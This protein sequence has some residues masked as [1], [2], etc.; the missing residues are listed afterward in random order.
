MILLGNMD[1]VFSSGQMAENIKDIGKMEN[2]MAK[3]STLDQMARKEKENGRRE[4][5][6]SGLKR[7]EK[8]NS[9]LRYNLSAI[10]CTFHSLSLFVIPATTHL[11]KSLN[12]YLRRP[13]SHT[14]A[15]LRFILISPL[16]FLE[17]EI[18]Y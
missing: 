10:S 6:S 3:E 9:D 1:M 7:M 2:S 18:F 5:E 16:S 8:S 4:R 17:E 15:Q 14:N 12:S 11:A 13:N